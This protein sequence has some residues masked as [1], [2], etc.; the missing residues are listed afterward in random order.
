MAAGRGVGGHGGRLV[1]ATLA[2]T[3]AATLGMLACRRAPAGPA[4]TGAPGAVPGSEVAERDPAGGDPVPGEPGGGNPVAEA[5]VEALLGAMSLEQ[6]VGQL[7][8][9]G[10]RGRSA[11]DDPNL[12]RFLTEGRFGGIILFDA[13]VES[14]AQVARLVAQAQAMAR[15]VEGGVP[16][17]VAVDQE[18]GSVARLVAGATVFPGAMALGAIYAADAAAGVRAAYE[19]ARWTARE[20]RAVGVNL[21]LAPVADVNSDP[22]NPVIGARSFGEDPGLVARLVQAFVRGTQDEGVLATAKH[23]PGHGDT[24]VDSHL[25]LPAIPHARRRLEAVELVPFRAAIEAGVAAVMSGH[26]T[27]PALEPEPGLP[28]TLSRRIMTGLLR[29][30][31]GFGGLAVTDAMEMRAITDHLGRYDAAWRAVAAGADLVLF[32]GDADLVWGSYRRALEA[33]RAGELPLARVEEAAGRVLGAKFRLGLFEVV[34]DPEAAAARAREAVGTVEARRAAETM[35]R[36][37]VTLVRDDRGLVPLAPQP[38]QKVLVVAPAVTALAEPDPATGHR[39]SLAAAVT[40]HHP[41]T[42]EYVYPSAAP[43]EHRDAVRALAAQVDVV[44]VATCNAHLNP[45]QAALVRELLATGRPV[46]V[47]ALGD[48]YDLLAFEAAPLYLVTYGHRPAA[49]AAA[50][51]VLFGAEPARGRLPVSLPGLAPAGHGLPGEGGS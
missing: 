18:G 17:L 19:A 32:A 14:P 7:F 35:Y 38:G 12:R 25:A 24:A 29:E 49:V 43:R 23:F 27:F 6:K 21:N 13:N 39:S 34:P 33:V 26:I 11:A 28:A 1:A 36:Q 3:L 42:R 37:S 16:L 40:A 44:V 31:L 46:A 20:L 30:E 8:V 15:G 2:L 4:V 50:V 45:D 5:E 9:T 10:F 48:P 22:R 47:I 41:G 51:D